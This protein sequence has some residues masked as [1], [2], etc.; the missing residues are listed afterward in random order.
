MRRRTLCLTLALMLAGGPAAALTAWDELKPMIFGERDLVPAG[1]DIAISSPYRTDNDARTPIGIRV[2][3]PEGR[4]VDKVTVILDENPMPVS[5]VI[6]LA[7]PLPALF[8]ELTLRFNG[9]TPMH[10]VAETTDGQAWVAEAFVKTSG[11]G[12]CAAPPGTDAEAALATL[13]Q[14]TIEMAPLAGG[15][16]AA[17][18]LGALAHREARVDVDIQHPSLSG[19]QKDQITLLFIPMRYVETLEVELDGAPYAEVTGSISLSEN[20]RISLSAPGSTR[21]VGVTMT[22]TDGTVTHAE[23]T[24]P[25]Y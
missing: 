24:F 11:Q 18:R 2:R 7:E 5:A 21:S 17:A 25:G 19:L 8:F 4:L 12:A 22:D 20:P 14:M 3:G 9:P 13:G 6:A 10:V 1:A 23:R 16:G 15:G